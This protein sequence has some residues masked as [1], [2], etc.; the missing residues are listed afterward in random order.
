MSAAPARTPADEEQT[1]IALARAAAG[2][3]LGP[4][5]LQAIWRIRHSR[6]NRLV[7]EGA[8]DPFRVKPAIGPR[9][10]SGVLV[11]RYLQG[12]DALYEPSFGRKKRA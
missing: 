11:H 7:H 10:Y 6:F 9:C 8:F 4:L 1:R 2:E 3:L 5:D 12:G